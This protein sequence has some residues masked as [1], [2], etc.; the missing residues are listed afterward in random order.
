MEIDH[1]TREAA[2]CGQTKIETQVVYQL[3][4]TVLPNH[5]RL[6]YTTSPDIVF[7]RA[8]NASRWL[9]ST[10]AQTSSAATTTTDPKRLLQNTIII[11]RHEPRPPQTRFNIPTHTHSI[12]HLHD[13]TKKFTTVHAE[14]LS[15]RLRLSPRLKY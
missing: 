9:S 4:S 6:A 1:A 10:R 8:F 11:N 14:S 13:A 3:Y 2:L 7:V 12:P 15:L 5:T